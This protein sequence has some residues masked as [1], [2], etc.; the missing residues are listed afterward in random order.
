[1]KQ[2]V[3]KLINTGS[4]CFNP[5]D[6]SLKRGRYI[7]TVAGWTE[8]YISDYTPEEYI[9]FLQEEAS[10][11]VEVFAEAEPK[12]NMF[13]DVGTTDSM[14]CVTCDWA[15]DNLEE[16]IATALKNEVYE[17]FDS[18]YS[19]YIYIDEEGNIVEIEDEE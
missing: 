9:K 13:I 19:D 16:T 8:E 5:F 3:D 7:F 14:Y 10:D 15:S 4:V 17:I 18:E 11:Y 2:I 1:M 12:E 6:P